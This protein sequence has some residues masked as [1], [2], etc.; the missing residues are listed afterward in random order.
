VPVALLLALVACAPEPAPPVVPQAPTAPAAPAPE[1]ALSG[2]PTLVAPPGVWGERAAQV[3]GVLLARAEKAPGGGWRWP[4]VGEDG[5]TDYPLAAYEGQAGV[6]L[7][8]AELHRAAPQPLLAQALAEG[9]KALEASLAAQRSLDTGLYSGWA[10]VGATA[11]ALD[12]ALGDASWREQARQ[13]GARVEPAQDFMLD[14]IS[15]AAGQGL[16]LL[17]LH[18]RTGEARWLTAARAHGDWLLRQGVAADGGTAVGGTAWPMAVRSELVYTGLSHGTAGVGYFLA[19]L[20][21]AVGAAA[22]DGAGAEGAAEAAR[23]YREGAE[24][25]AR[26]LRA[27]ARQTDGQV[28]WHRRAPDQLD[29]EQDQWCHGPAGIG[30]FFL[31]LHALTRAEEDLAWARKSGEATAAHG[32]RLGACLCHGNPGNAALFLALHRATGEPLWRARAEAFAAATWSGRT[33]GRDGLPSWPSVD[34]SPTG[35]HNPGLLV[36]GAGVGH[37]LLRLDREATPDFPLLGGP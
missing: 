18:A 22:G 33:P 8:L 29:R 2:V 5:R 11:L 19:H 31:A 1:R 27:V 9:G 16:F 21:R 15:G 34:G 7:F 23:P 28:A 14:V 10:G 17:A 26:H 30:H 25:A 37:L 24:A 12:A 6:L 4:V 3:A 35:A 20:A 36:G 32:A 13:A